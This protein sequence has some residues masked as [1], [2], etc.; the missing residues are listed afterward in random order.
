MAHSLVAKSKRFD[1]SGMV[2]Y[3][4]LTVFGVLM[5]APLVYMVSS[6]FKPTSELFLFPP[7]FFVMNPTSKNFSDLLL[8]TG[9]SFS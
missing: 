9:T 5:L 6:A 1:I 7:R 4:L 3:A 8:A 2:M